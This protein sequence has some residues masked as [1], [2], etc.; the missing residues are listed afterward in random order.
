VKAR[1]AHV[2]KPFGTGERACI[3]RQFAVHEATLALATVLRRY[4][5]VAPADY[6]LRVAEMLTLK[7]EGFTVTPR[8]R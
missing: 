7:P 4:D 5:L 1:P 2:H 3:G 8:R 6:E